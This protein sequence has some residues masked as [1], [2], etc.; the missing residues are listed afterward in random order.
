[1]SGGYW[2]VSGR[3]RVV[4][5]Y[6]NTSG[7]W[8][9]SRSGWLLFAAIGLIWGIPYLLIKVAVAEISPATLVFLRTGIAALVLVPLAAT[10]GEL[11][12]LR[13]HWK[14]I[15]VYTLVEVAIPWFLLSDAERRLSSSLS[16][17]LVAT[18]PLIGM[19]LAQ[20]T[21]AEDRLDPRRGLGMA[22]GFFGVAALL[23]LD[24]SL[25]DSGAVAEVLGVTLCYAVGPMIIARRLS[26]VPS[27][28]V[29][30]ASLVLTAAI[31]APVAW[32]QRPPELPSLNVLIAILVLGSACTALAFVLFFALIAEIGPVRSQMITYV[33]PAVALVLGVTL[34]GEPFTLGDAIG[35]TL[36]LAG[37]LLVTRRDRRTHPTRAEPARVAV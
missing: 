30:A 1:M 20:F 16:G 37:L 6:D 33:N 13:P 8:S 11:R 35:F 12:P 26:R 21:G 19:L 7:L 34:L 2:N 14:A 3:L 9:V 25:V 31:Y 18:V 17:L 29:V 36:I 15:L 24:V 27:V 4:S 28:G 23:G 10:R 5:G 22:V 32:L